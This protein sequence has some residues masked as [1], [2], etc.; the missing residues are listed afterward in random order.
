MYNTYQI[1]V[2]DSMDIDELKEELKTADKNNNYTRVIFLFNK[3]LKNTN[4]I[5]FEL[6]SIYQK[7][8][9]KTGKKEEELEVLLKLKNI[10]KNPA[11]NIRLINLYLDL[12]NTEDAINIID[13]NDELKYYLLGK[14]CFLRGEYVRSLKMFKE[15]LNNKITD[16]NYF[17][18]AKNYINRINNHQQNNNFLEI[19][20]DKFKEQGKQLQ[21]GYIVYSDKVGNRYNLS[22]INLDSHKKTRPY[23]IWKINNEHIYCLPLSTS[24]SNDSY[25]IKKKKYS[26]LR[27]DS[28]LFENFILLKDENITSVVEHLSKEDYLK[29]MRFVY[30]KILILNKE[31]RK[32]EKVFI[33]NYM[34]RMKIKDNDIIVYHDNGKNI[35]SYYF[36]I[37]STGYKYEAVPVKKENSI[38]I[39]KDKRKISLSKK[40]PIFNVIKLKEEEKNSLIKQLEDAYLVQDLC[41]KKI[42]I[43][44][45]EKFVILH[46]LGSDYLTV[47]VPYSSSYARFKLISKDT[48]FDIDDE[49]SED[50]LNNLRYQLDE[51]I[52]IKKLCIPGYT[53]NNTLIKAKKIRYK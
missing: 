46:D 48:K 33:S 22:E 4:K 3:D 50:E 30:E 9:M 13:D 16:I 26:N 8:L 42:S 27:S 28:T 31:N 5:D 34:K 36:I 1:Q 14:I 23:L 15:Y 10:I 7:A 2:G 6:L 43:N 47:V 21:P 38:L 17:Y 19:Y 12:N 53:N 18:N 25:V 44:D 39:I 29:A 51:N 52:K 35:D 45:K 20:Y 11:Y 37:S 41:G 32:T 40:K 49:I 24:I